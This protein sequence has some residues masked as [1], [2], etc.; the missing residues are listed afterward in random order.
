MARIR[1]LESLG[2][3]LLATL[4]GFA[5]RDSVHA[6]NLVMLYLA[7]VVVAAI[8]LGRGPAILA[9][10]FSVLAYDYFFVEPRL[11]FSV[12][13][14]EY[15]ITFAGLLVVGLV[16]SSL[17]SQVRD[18]LLALQEREAQTEALNALSRDLAVAF[19]L[20]PMLQAVVR[21]TCR[22]LG[23]DVVVLVPEGG[24]L[25]EQAATPHFHLEEKELNIARW[26]FEHASPAGRGTDTFPE[27]LARYVPLQT[28][29][30]V[31]GILGVRPKEPGPYLTS[32]QRQQL[33][34]FAN[35]TALAIERARLVDQA[36]QARLLNETEKLQTALLNSISHDLRTPLVS[37]KGVLDSLLEIEQG[38]ANSPQLDRADRLDMLEN[39]REETA[40]LNR[41]V[42]N[43]LDMTRLESGALKVRLEP[44]DLQDVIGSALARLNEPLQGHPLVVEIAEGL[45]LAPMDFVLI[46]QVLVNLLDNAV[47]YSLPGAPLDISARRQGEEAL[48]QVLDRGAG[49][50]AV[51]LE[52]VFEKFHRVKGP[53]KAKGLGL[54]LSICKGIVEAHHGRI[55][56]ENRPGGGTVMAFTLPL[57]SQQGLLA[58]SAANNPK[59]KETND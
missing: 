6:P 21:H 52:R 43:L 13:D 51:E 10:V 22:T 45:P 47:K 36:N 27:G 15:L 7:A 54:G 39:A 9:S 37:I 1:Y 20:D 57:N 28:I 26:A 33:E 4:V 34:G 8:Y 14:T 53:V 59:I 23:R 55:W 50:P 29:R 46:E 48:V 16:V 30:G 3:V 19:D 24:R 17:T 38:G 56:A 25:V 32:V 11:S 35:L 31:V 41:L 49:I 18:Q 58:A 44:A 42:E 5:F 40:R 2:I 12:A